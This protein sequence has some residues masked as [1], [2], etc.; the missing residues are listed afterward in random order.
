MTLRCLT[1]KIKAPCI[2]LNMQLD[3]GLDFCVLLVVNLKHCSCRFRLIQMP[4]N[5]S[6]QLIRDLIYASFNKEMKWS[7]STLTTLT[8][9]T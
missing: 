2:D 1:L 5:E 4:R 8:F 3:I 9:Y 6:E 7:F